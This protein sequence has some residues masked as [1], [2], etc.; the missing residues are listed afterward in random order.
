[1]GSDWPFPTPSLPL[2]CFNPRSPHG[3]RPLIRLGI[4][5]LTPV[6][7]HAPRMGSDGSGT[8]ISLAIG[9]FQSTLP[10][11]G[12][13]HRRRLPGFVPAC[14]NPRSPHGERRTEKITIYT[15]FSFQ[16]TLPAWGATSIT[17]TGVWHYVVSIHAPR[18]GSDNYNLR[19]TV[20]RDAFQSTL[21]AWGATVN[22]FA[23]RRNDRV[24]IHAPRMGSDSIIVALCF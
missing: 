9:L 22:E 17:T 4:I 7:I 23:G 2:Y 20:N 18:M 11:W 13:T 19:T 16:S 21:P 24:S 12:A 3:E 5:S 8:L 10:A 15:I 1:M 14:F 6:S